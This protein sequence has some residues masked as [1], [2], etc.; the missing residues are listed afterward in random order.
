MNPPQQEETR[1]GVG[2]ASDQVVTTTTTQ[3]LTEP[4][5]ESLVAELVR[6]VRL[7]REARDRATQRRRHQARAAVQRTPTPRLTADEI[8]VQRATATLYARIIKLEKN[9]K[10]RWSDY[11]DDWV[12]RPVFTRTDQNRPPT[13]TETE[14]LDRFD[15]VRRN[16]RGW[17]SRCPAHEDNHPSLAIIE[18]DRGWL[19]KCWANCDFRD[20]VDAA[21]LETQRMF[22]A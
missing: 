12:K 11:V 8:K 19:I 3:N 13:Y 9:G 15:K 4:A 22:F 10:L 7:R 6:V 1:P 21:G 18:G 17:T 20:I 2:R 5:G 14:L 16:G